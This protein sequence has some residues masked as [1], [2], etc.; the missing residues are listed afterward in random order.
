V[1]FDLPGLEERKRML[2]QYLKKYLQGA[3][4]ATR[5]VVDPAVDGKALASVASRTEGFSGRE[6]AKLAI[7][8]QAAAYGST[9]AAFGPEL[10]ES[11]LA[12]H[13]DQK[14]RKLLWNSAAAGM[15]YRV[16]K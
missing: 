13:K 14:E 10:L 16:A 15:A 8:W 7:A 5:I 2:D 11:V 4:G 3:S 6:I 9:N 12:A 1:E